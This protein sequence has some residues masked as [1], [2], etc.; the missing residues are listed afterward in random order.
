MTANS[1]G[2]TA[3][4]IAD[5]RA[6]TLGEGVFWHPQREQLFWFDILGKRLLSQQDGQPLEWALGERASA[7]GWIDSDRLLMASETALSVFDLRNGSREQVCALEANNPL[8]RSNDGRADP[9]G[10]F[11][12]GTMG[13]LAQPQAGAIY[14]YYRGELRRL[15][16]DLSITN[17]ICFSPDRRFAYFADTARQQIWRQPLDELHGWPS[18]EPQRFIDGRVAGL[19]PDG[20]VIDN[21]GRLW[22]AQWGA[23]RV[24]CYDSEGQF[25]QAVAFPA[26][27]ISCPAFGGPDL[28]ILFATSAR[29]GLEDDGLDAEPHAGK[30]FATDVPA[31]GQAEYQVVL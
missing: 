25:L 27:Q 4:R 20:A 21:Q 19:N 11:W 30:L 10:G 29:D 7:A 8:T 23:S 16:G 5:S 15:F 26:S 28:S 13:L 14:R 2:S 6:C 22:N 24:A 1:H 31:Q 12:I 9:W 3:A 18:G 17:A